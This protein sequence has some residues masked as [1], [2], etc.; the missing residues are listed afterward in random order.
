[1]TL[2]LRVA[3]VLCLTISV[4]TAQIKSPS[5]SYENQ[6]VESLQRE[7]SPSL[8]AAGLALLW[9]EGEVIGLDD[10]T[11]LPVLPALYYEYSYL[12]LPA[13]RK[14]NLALVTAPQLMF[15]VFGLRLPA[16]IDFRLGSLATRKTEVG[17]RGLVLGTGYEYLKFFGGPE[18]STTYLRGG[19]AI[20]R[21]FVLYQ[22]GFSGDLYLGNLLFGVKFDI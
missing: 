4:C 7:S 16:G 22:H 19:V 17:S 5:F 13:A 8:H 9:I 12:L 21:F 2:K 14:S 18:F 11:F 10:V 20:E 1:M 3:V 6:E 15:P